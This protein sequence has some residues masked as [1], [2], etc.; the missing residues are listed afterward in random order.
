MQLYKS[1]NEVRLLPSQ[2]RLPRTCTGSPFADSS[3][4]ARR[5]TRSGRRTRSSCTTSSSPTP[6]TGPRS[7]ASGSPTSRRASCSPLWPPLLHREPVLT[8]LPRPAGPPTRTTRST[9]SCSRHTPRARTTTTSRSP[10]STSPSPRP[11]SAST[12][13]MT[14]AAVRP[15]LPLDPRSP[16]LLVELTLSPFLSSLLQRSART[17]RPSPGSRSPSRSTTRA[18]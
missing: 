17:R 7:P 6:S 1:I 4:D 5:S 18:R 16:T 10:R 12:S 14:S 8:P 9:A 15:H 11:A 3:T 13:T 2:P